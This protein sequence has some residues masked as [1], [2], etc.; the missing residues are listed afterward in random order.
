VPKIGL[1]IWSTNLRYI[2]IARELFSRQVFDYIELFTVPGSIETL[3]L[4]NDLAVPYILHAPH[5]YAGLDPSVA[6]SRA[7]NIE[8]VAQVDQF[9]QALSPA[10]VIFHPGVHGQVSE[11]ISQFRSFGYK[12]PVMYEKVLIENKPLIGLR[13]ETCL[14][15]APDEM[16]RIL[17]ATGRGFCLD[18]GHAICYAVAAGKEWKQVLAEFL[19][20]RPSM[21]HLCDGHF[22]VK[23]AHEHLGAGEFDL[24]YLI[25]LIEDGKPVSLETKRDRQD[26]LDDF[27]LDAQKLREHAGIQNKG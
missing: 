5:T 27:V 8:L 2:P 6:A 13:E 26:S 12:F 19:K 10:H 9:F 4:W 15:A 17:D 24:P 25:Q 7:L 23:D 20:L 18:F 3:P 11:S 21:Y 16:R 14:G 1:K 22:T